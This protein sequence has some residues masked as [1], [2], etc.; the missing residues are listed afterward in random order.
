MTST[1]SLGE[2]VKESWRAGERERERERERA[3]E[4][5]L[6]SECSYA[7]ERA[8]ELLR[9]RG[10]KLLAL[11]YWRERSPHLSS[12]FFPSREREN[13]SLALSISKALTRS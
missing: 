10:G 11:E 5:A 8:S 9:A 6:E 2:L 7:P 13:V 4:R 12:T 1:H 3:G